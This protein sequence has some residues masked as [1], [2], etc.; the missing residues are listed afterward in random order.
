MAPS[1]DRQT[2]G[3]VSKRI[4]SR[5]RASTN[6]R[7]RNGIETGLKRVQNGSGGA[8]FDTL[9]SP[10]YFGAFS[11]H[12]PNIPRAKTDDIDP[13]PYCVLR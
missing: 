1:V 10:D 7:H 11:T 12:M 2:F 13:S 4:H 3:S 5:S 6:Y 9:P 8:R